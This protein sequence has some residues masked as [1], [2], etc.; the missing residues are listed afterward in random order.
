MGLNHSQSAIPGLEAFCRR[1]SASPLQGASP[2]LV[3]TN[4]MRPIHSRS[5]PLT[6]S[7]CMMRTRHAAGSATAQALRQSRLKQPLGQSQ[8]ARARCD[9]AGGS[10]NTFQVAIT[11]WLCRRMLSDPALQQGARM[12]IHRTAAPSPWHPTTMA[13]RSLPC[14]VQLKCRKA[15]HSAAKVLSLWCNVLH[16]QRECGAYSR[17]ADR[18]KEAD[19]SSTDCNTPPPL[20]TRSFLR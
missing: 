6:V 17:D 10:N 12:R 3:S 13:E 15:L 7:Q 1:C 14:C 2:G 16:S 8:R 4:R 19:V 9:P 20:M 18:C 5:R 11:G